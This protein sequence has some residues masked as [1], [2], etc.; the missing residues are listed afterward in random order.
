MAALKSVGASDSWVKQEMKRLQ[1][2]EAAVFYDF[3][4]D[5]MQKI[6]RQ[7]VKVP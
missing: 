1:E 6:R 7:S 2:L 3:R 4:R 5:V